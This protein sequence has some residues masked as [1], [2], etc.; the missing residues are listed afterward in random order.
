MVPLVGI[1][2]ECRYEIPAEKEPLVCRYTDAVKKQI[3]NII[4]SRIRCT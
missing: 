1:L 2:A 4:S 3:L